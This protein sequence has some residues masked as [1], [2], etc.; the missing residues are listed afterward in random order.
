MTQ[1]MEVIGL[2][3]SVMTTNLRTP[4]QTP[5]LWWGVPVDRN[6]GRAS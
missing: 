3:H 6:T 2:G 4:Q 5:G 1:M